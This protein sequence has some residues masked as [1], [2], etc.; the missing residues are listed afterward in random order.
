MRSLLIFFVL[1]FTSIV[2]CNPVKRETAV[3]TAGA[4]ASAVAVASADSDQPSA[5]TANTVILPSVQN[6]ASGKCHINPPQIGDPRL[7]AILDFLLNGKTDNS[8]LFITLISL[9]FG[10]NQ[11]TDLI[12]CPL[13]N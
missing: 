4:G 2:Y 7:Q 12:Y 11:F 9:I 1:Y 8:T 5:T 10:P 13:E 6:V 3:A